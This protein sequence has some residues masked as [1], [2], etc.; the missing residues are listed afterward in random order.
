ME[1]NPLT[2]S[3]IV[4]VAV[5]ILLFLWLKLTMKNHTDA[6]Y[7]K[8]EDDYMITDFGRKL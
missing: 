5:L 7:F 8:P 4:V 1:M 6:E 2:V 3:I